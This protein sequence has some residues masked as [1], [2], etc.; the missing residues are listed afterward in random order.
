MKKTLISLKK[1]TKSPYSENTASQPILQNINLDIKAGSKVA[2]LGRS[3]S[4]KTTLM[5]IIGLM[6]KASAGTYF[7]QGK[8]TS[9]F[10]DLTLS[11]TRGQMIGY[12]FQSFHLLNNLSLLENVLL[13]QRYYQGPKIENIQ[14]HALNLLKQVNLSHR[15]KTKVSVLS[16]G[17]KQRLAIARALVNKPKI[18]LADEPTGAL[19]SKTRDMIM[20]L[21]AQVH[22]EYKLTSI[23]VTHDQDIAN[24]GNM[25]ITILDG[26]ITDV[27]LS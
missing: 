18:L 6:A 4:G 26:K 12:V 19:D 16:G 22:E 2:I 17:E 15:L 7:L 8:D 23:I 14:E 5:N 20:G 3:G 27:N 13:P 1:I 9:E 11:I 25:I 10:D 21:F 24:Y